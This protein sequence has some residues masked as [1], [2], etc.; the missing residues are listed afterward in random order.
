MLKVRLYA[1]FSGESAVPRVHAAGGRLLQHVRHAW[2]QQVDDG[3]RAELAGAHAG[4]APGH[5]GPLPAR[6]ARIE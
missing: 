3:A 5:H 6:R 4:H 2:L 1:M